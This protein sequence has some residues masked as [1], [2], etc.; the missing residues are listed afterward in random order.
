MASGPSARELVRSAAGALTFGVLVGALLTPPVAWLAAALPAVV[1]LW[2]AA[3][4]RR[5]LGRG[6]QGR[7][8]P[9]RRAHWMSVATFAAV[10]A[11]C[12]LGAA[13]AL[14]AGL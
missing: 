12:A 1:A 3:S 14:L 10:S 2:L 11:M 13:A 6:E 9:L 7:T 5:L 8:S 4:T